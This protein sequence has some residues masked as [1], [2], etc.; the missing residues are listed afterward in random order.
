MR[1]GRYAEASRALEQVI[2]R[3]Y[4]LR[5]E[6]VENLA[7]C[8]RQ[9]GKTALAEKADAALARCGERAKATPLAQ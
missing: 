6:D 7:E 5:R 1:L 9:E 3:D 2:R 8:L 4:F